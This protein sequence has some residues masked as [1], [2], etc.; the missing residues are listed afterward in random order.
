MV[1]PIPDGYSTVTPYLI[2]ND[3]KSALEF[4]KNAFGAKELFR[5]P[6]GDSIAHAELQIGNSRIMLSNESPQMEHYSAKHYD[7]SPVSLMIYV[8][9]VDSAAKDAVAAGAEIYR[10]VH[11][12]FYGDRRGTFP[13]PFGY[14]WTI[15][16]RVEDV[17]TEEMNQR[18]AKMVAAD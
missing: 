1:K 10:P 7:G 2:L 17:S 8:E 13:D 3:A 11:N 15:A 9:D 4:Y 5:M 16:T 12:H 14:R 18:I 6:M